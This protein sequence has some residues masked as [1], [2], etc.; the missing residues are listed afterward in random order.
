MG[1]YLS[2]ARRADLQIQSVSPGGVVWDML[3]SA[4]AD[5]MADPLERSLLPDNEIA[6]LREAG[7]RSAG[8]AAIWRIRDSL[9]PAHNAR[10]LALL[11]QS[12]PRRKETRRVNI[13]L[14]DMSL[15]E[16]LS[17]GG[18][19]LKEVE[20]DDVRSGDTPKDTQG[21]EGDGL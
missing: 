13:D 21:T 19:D 14:K 15:S 20:V 11:V 6:R 4:L 8:E 2:K 3:D 16:L 12:M 9:D 17:A 7:C 5:A 1:V 10:F 18:I